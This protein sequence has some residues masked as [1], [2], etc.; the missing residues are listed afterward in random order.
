MC[1]DTDKEKAVS[2]TLNQQ[3]LLK[4]RVFIRL[5]LHSFMTALYVGKAFVHGYVYSFVI[6]HIN[7]LIVSTE[8]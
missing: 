6:S 2:A 7:S 4:K 1:C 3:N 5:S 8:L